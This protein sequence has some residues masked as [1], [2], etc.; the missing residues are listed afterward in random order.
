[1][2]C[3]GRAGDRFGRW[4]SRRRETRGSVVR[5]RSSWTRADGRSERRHE[6]CAVLAL[7]RAD[8]RAGAEN[9][10]LRVALESRIVI[11][12]AKG[13][14][15]ERFALPA[16]AVFEL[17]RSAARRSRRRLR[18]VAGDIVTT[19]VTPGYLEREIRQLPG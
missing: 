3:R 2:S 11:E 12:Q 14:L 5:S 6:R 18:D 8:R 16:E 17:L 9:R 4:L 10:Y 1:M 13:V 19:R 7:L 15:V